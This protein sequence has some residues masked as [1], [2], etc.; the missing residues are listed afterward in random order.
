MVKRLPTVRETWVRSLSREDPLAK[1][2][3]THSS[4]LAWEIPWTEEPGSY[5]PRGCKESDTTGQLSTQANPN[6]SSAYSRGPENEQ[7]NCSLN[8]FNSLMFIFLRVV[9]EDGKLCKYKVGL[10]EP[11]LT[12]IIMANIPRSSCSEHFNMGE[13]TR[14][15]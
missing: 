15:L 13:L 2:M 5:N 9:T 6:L 1:E 11:L 4:L 14:T 10:T 7:E 12:T 3:A 8:D